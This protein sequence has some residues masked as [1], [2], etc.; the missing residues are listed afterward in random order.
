MPIAAQVTPGTITFDGVGTDDSDITINGVF[1]GDRL[2]GSSWEGW[3]GAEGF[4]N[5]PPEV[6][7]R[8]LSPDPALTDA[9][10]VSADGSEFQLDALDFENFS[11]QIFD[12][13]IIGYRDGSQVA[14]KTKTLS[15]TGGGNW[16]TIT[17]GSDFEN[18]DEVRVT[19]NG[20]SANNPSGL[21]MDN[22]VVD[23]AVTNTAPTVATNTGSTT[24][25]GTNDAITQNELEVT[26]A[27]Q[28]PSTLTYTIDSDVSEGDLF[29]TNTS[30]TLNQGDTF[31]QKDINDGFIEYQ[32]DGTEPVSEGFDFTVRDGDGG[33]VSGTFSITIYQVNDA[34]TISSLSDQTIQEDGTLNSLSFTVGDTEKD[35]LATL[36]LTASSSNTNLV[37]FG[38]SEDNI[39]F[40]R[41]DADGNAAIT[42]EPLPNES[43]TTTITVVVDDGAAA[44]NTATEDFAL[45]VNAVPDL[46]ITDGR[47]S[48]LDFS[49][50]VS[51]GTNDN[52]I[53]IFKLEAGQSGA[54][55]DGVTVTNTAPGVEGISAARLYWSSDQT[56]EPATDTELDEVTTDVTSAPSTISFSGFSQSIPTS[57]RYVILAIDVEP[58]ATADVSFEL[59]DESALTTS[60]GELA[61]VNGSS[62]SS[63]SGLRLSNGSTALPVELARFDATT[64]ETEGV[65]LQ[66]Q[67]ASETD[68]AEFE[69][70]RRVKVS[71]RDAS[72]S[73]DDWQ[74]VGSVDGAGTT[75]EAQSYRFTDE[76][77]PF[78][79]DSLTYRLKQVDTDGSTSYSE[80][81]TI[82]RPTP[83]QVQLLGTSPNPARSRATVQFAVPEGAAREDVHLGLYDALGRQVRTVRASAEAGRHRLQ[84]NTE[85]LSS[86][87]YF[88]RLQA[89][90]TIKTQKLT[91][92]R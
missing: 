10:F 39:T 80:P 61:T 43:G 42:V 34:P 84:L 46:S 38:P 70:Q 75:T 64:S 55:F 14:S 7:A 66:W 50:S 71:R 16:V 65:T 60:G 26:D 51:P 22:V 79:A 74:T 68:N 77:V 53:G 67:T 19:T 82:A 15:Q 36:T 35:D 81:V 91:V 83:Q 8:G 69:V 9:R 11:S 86:G 44:N 58:D 76:E 85:Q 92:V 17:F 48:N 78:D 21:A 45:T 12:A 5:P 87:V 40:T 59:A 27:E 73:G 20:Y 1:F 23:D 6:D 37:P 24:D 33:S 88:L 25:E 31:T 72:T 89:G 47:S 49:S 29:N 32:H 4:G 54:S 2:G 90:T 56:L 3:I 18:I 52:P 57:A 62:Q 13:V 28:D 41:P 30:T 63:F